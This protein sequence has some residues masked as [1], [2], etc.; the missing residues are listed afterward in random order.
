MNNRIILLALL[1]LVVHK[2]LFSQSEN[3]LRVDLDCYGLYDFYHATGGVAGI[4]AMADFQLSQMVCF[5]VGAEVVS[6]KRYAVNL[7]GVTRICQFDGGGLYVKNRYLYRQWP[8]LDMQE[9][10]GALAA[11]WDGR[12]LDAEIGLCNR[13]YAAL[14]QRSDGGMNTIFEP[15]NV[16]FALEVSLFGDDNRSWDLS[17]RW[18]NHNDFIIERVTAW[19]YSLK[20]YYRF[21]ERCRLIV[22]AG[23]HPVG[24]LNLTSSYNGWFVHAGVSVPLKHS[25]NQ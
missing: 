16:M 7:S 4:A 6:S 24:S 2:P 21:T 23:F 19:M 11:G 5:K 8:F 22:E 18:S 25:E 3:N 10:S 13:Y 12:R 14:V 1:C 15:M 17:A 9:F 20:G